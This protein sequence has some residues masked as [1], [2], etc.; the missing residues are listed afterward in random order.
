M[1]KKRRTIYLLALLTLLVTSCQKEPVI[2]NDVVYVRYKNAEMP[3]YIYGNFTNKIFIIYLHGGPGGNGLEYR[4]E[5]MT[6]RIE[7]QYAVVYFDQRNAGMS[8]GAFTMDDLTIDLM[9]EDVMALVKVIQ[10]KYG[11]DCQFFLMGHSWGG[12]LGV[13]TLLNKNNQDQ[14]AG[15]IEVDGAHDLA[16]A[17]VENI[18]FMKQICHEQLNLGNSVDFWSTV[19]DSL[20]LVDS[21][22]YNLSDN[23]YINSTATEAEQYLMDD[24]ILSYYEFT[25]GGLMNELVA[26]TFRNNP[27]TCKLNGRFGNAVLSVNGIWDRISYTEEIADVKIPSLFMWGKYDMVVPPTLGQRAYEL[28]GASD[29][30]FVLFESSGHS[31][32]YQETSKFAVSIINFIERNR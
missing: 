9:A 13:A 22:N 27:I 18:R 30:E 14:F 7:P 32:M 4:T 17:Y 11:S 5:I 15:W 23:Y 1:G 19:K 10:H 31:P 26:I 25:L 2:L 24:G 16:N 29:K 8:Q 21:I 3:A 20:M 12:A 6:S 28:S